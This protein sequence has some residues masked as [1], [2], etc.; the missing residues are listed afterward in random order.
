MGKAKTSFIGGETL[1]DFANRITVA[2]VHLMQE[3]PQTQVLYQVLRFL[4]IPFLVWLIDFWADSFLYLALCFKTVESLSD[5]SHVVV[6]DFSNSISV[7]PIA[8]KTIRLSPS[9]AYEDVVSF[10]ILGI[11]YTMDPLN[12]KFVNFGSLFDRESLSV[13]LKD[14][15]SG[16]SIES[17]ESAEEGFGKNVIKVEPPNLV[18]IGIKTALSSLNI[19]G[20]LIVLMATWDSDYLGIFAG[21]LG[22]SLSIREEVTSALNTYVETQALVESNVSV[23]VIRK[24]AKGDI[25]KW[26]VP[27][28]DLL[29]GDLVEVTNNLEMRADI[30]L[31]SGSC[32]VTDSSLTGGQ[33]EEV[34]VAVRPEQCEKLT[35]AEV[36]V[37][38]KIFAG[39]RCSYVRSKIN[40]SV[41]G[42][43]VAT[44]Y[45]TKQGQIMREYLLPKP[46]NRRNLEE[47]SNFLLILGLIAV[48][49]CMCF[50]IYLFNYKGV[51][52][53]V[54]HNVF[55]CFFVFVSD[56]INPS[57][58]Y[59][60]LF[61]I[62]ASSRRLEENNVITTNPNLLNQCGR[63]KHIFY[64]K[65]G[66]LTL[67]ESIVK[68]MIPNPVFNVAL[69]D[70]APSAQKSSQQAPDA[71]RKLKLKAFFAMLESINKGHLLETQ[72]KEVQLVDGGDKGRLIDFGVL[73]MDREAHFAMAVCLCNSLTVIGS[74]MVGTDYESQLLLA[75]PFAL[76]Q[77]GKK[78]VGAKVYQLKPEFKALEGLFGTLEVVREL[79]YSYDDVKSSVLLR[80]SLGHCLLVTKGSPETIFGISRPDSLP[81]DAQNA[82]FK[83]SISGFRVLGF[84]VRKLDA[85][86]LT[87]PRSDL[88]KD[89]VFVGMLSLQNDLRPSVPEV[90]D[91]LSA[92]Q[93]RQEVIT[94]DNLYSAVA[95]ARH[96]HIVTDDMVVFFSMPNSDDT[97]DGPPIAWINLLKIKHGYHQGGEQR[98]TIGH[99][100]SA[101]LPDVVWSLEELMAMPQKVCL[102]MT[103]ECYKVL[104]ERYGAKDDKDSLDMMRLVHERCLV[105][106]RT[107]PSV[108]KDIVLDSHRY[109]MSGYESMFVGDDDNDV[110]AM[111]ACKIS[112]LLK[113]TY[114]SFKATFTSKDSNFNSVLYLLKEGKC[115]HETGNLTF[116]FSIFTVVQ[117]LIV[118][119]YLLPF[120]LIYSTEMAVTITYLVNLFLI[121]YISIFQP[122]D[123]L[124]KSMPSS[125]LFNRRFLTNLLLH[126]LWAM[127]V[128]SLAYHW[129]KDLTFYADP[130]TIIPF[131]NQVAMNFG[132]NA[133]KLYEGTLFFVLELLLA[134]SFF[135]VTNYKTENRKSLLSQKVAF[136]YFICYFSFF[137]FLSNL[138]SID[139]PGRVSMFFINLYNIIKAATTNRIF[140]VAVVMFLAG[141]ITIEKGSSLAMAYRDEVKLR[142]NAHKFIQYQSKRQTKEAV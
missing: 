47:A 48:N 123:K 103:G 87:L 55:V 91:A 92:V 94:G 18:V 104:R 53:L 125:T 109:L 90:I 42:I 98:E 70:S 50:G 83:E 134:G 46:F 59:T 67:E 33:T 96:A 108:K 105:W 41:L 82:L 119:F 6:V 116:K 110:E 66:T 61:G 86:A 115:S 99:Q 63:I 38:S 76:A 4:P 30:V 133:F 142:K 23:I 9:V 44:A 57:L 5:A 1:S 16:R 28:T 68:V 93:V 84:A 102:A 139:E 135:L 81:N 114:F 89:M 21:L 29:P 122:S 88:E 124:G 69:L 74:I 101:E 19:M 111:T 72:F 75:G 136:Y 36:P 34:K 52:E 129:V 107:T 71:H 100:H 17:V 3:R 13:F 58:P 40:K 95:I 85:R 39:S 7:S 15:E 137:V 132:F 49:G 62:Q 117:R 118:S 2:K 97:A 56:V 120:F 141:S 27:T 26:S 24:N 11:I 25:M 31:V 51:V 79:E 35:L 22:V 65:T 8:R 20:I 128:V 43:V 37:K 138:P 140:I 131:E 127:L 14:F 130:F 10:E 45:H 113:H 78:E 60:L 32:I 112:F 64:D 54:P 126:A 77:S 106:A 12:N 73:D 80:S 121:G